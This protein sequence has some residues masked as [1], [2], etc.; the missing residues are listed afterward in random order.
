MAIKIAKKKLYNHPSKSLNAHTKKQIKKVGPK[1]KKKIP[2]LLAI[3]NLQNHFI[4]NFDFWRN[5]ANY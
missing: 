3:E 5:L 2:S 4:F 1:K